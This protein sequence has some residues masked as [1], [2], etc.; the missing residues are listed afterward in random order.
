MCPKMSP[1]DLM[2]ST[3]S[4]LGGGNN[5]NTTLQGYVKKENF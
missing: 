2:L 3:R 5:V 4:I 1:R